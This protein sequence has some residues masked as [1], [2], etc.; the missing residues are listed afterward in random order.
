MSKL[1][2]YNNGS[3]VWESYKMKR[4]RVDGPAV[5]DPNGAR[6]WYIHGECIRSEYP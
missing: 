5:I 2:I 1:T 3:L 4:H 6:E